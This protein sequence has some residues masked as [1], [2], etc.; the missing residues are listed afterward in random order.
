MINRTSLLT[1]TAVALVLCAAPVYAQT[2][3]KEGMPNGGA[4]GG[5]GR[6]AQKEQGTQGRATGQDHKGMTQGETKEQKPGKSTTQSEPSGNAKGTAENQSKEPGAKGS[7]QTQP[8]EPSGKGT[9]QTQ[10]EIEKN[11]KG[12]AETQPQRKEPGTRGT[13]QTQPK[14]PSGKGGAQTQQQTEPN[15][16][17]TA[18]KNPSGGDRVQLSEQQRTKV[19]RTILKESNVNR[20]TNVNFAVNVGTHVPRSVR[21]AALPAAVLSIVPQYRSYHYFVANDQICIVDPRSYEI[22][23]VIAAPGRTAGTDN[24]GATARLVS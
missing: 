10:Q 22:V 21:L 1:S 11:G 14:E 7:A 16:K 19:N 20:A 3:H 9:A 15:G 4:T 23:E 6:A 18:A 8:K 5:E 12:T 24:R 2:S 13:A 17:G